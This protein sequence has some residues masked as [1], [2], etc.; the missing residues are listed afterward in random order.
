MLQ[1]DI[2]QRE[3]AIQ[4][5]ETQ[6]LKLQAQIQQAIPEVDEEEIKRSLKKH[7]GNS[8]WFCLDQRSQRDLVT[9][10]KH[11]FLIR[12]DDFTADASD[13]SE[14]GIRLG[15]VAE[16]EVVQ[17]FFKSLRE[18][19]INNGHVDE[20]AGLMLSNNKKFTLGMM[21]AL[22]TE[23]W[24]TFKES[25]L[26][27]R[28]QSNDLELF[29]TVSYGQQVSESDRTQIQQFLQS[30]EHPLGPWLLNHPTQAAS[31]IDQI[32]KL[33][34][35]CAHAQDILHRW[36]FDFMAALIVG[37]DDQR[38]ILQEIFSSRK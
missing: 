4:H 23:Q 18:F 9:A 7:L 6:I 8:V 15:F 20:I 16:R 26:K 29:G 36:Q 14:A 11:D 19:L 32:N 1:S 35:I 5:H 38:G 10:Y 13:F 22:I 28:S 33:R 24:T 34:N 17:P 27:K 31:A 2:Q 25:A 37:D 21:P 3:L 30:W 12:A